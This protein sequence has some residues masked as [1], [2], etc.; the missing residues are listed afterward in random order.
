MSGL[1]E[2]IGILA[3]VPDVYGGYPMSRHHILRRLSRRWKVL[4]VSYPV[5]WLPA[6]RGQVDF[7]RRGLQKVSERLWCYAPRVPADYI[8]EYSG[9]GLG[10][11]LSRQ[12]AACWD[13]LFVRKIKHLLRRMDID[14]VILYIWRPEFEKYMEEFSELFT[15]YHIV[16]E[17]SFNPEADE[18]ISAREMSLLKNADVVFIHSKTLMQ[19]KG[20][21]NPNTHYVPNGVEFSRFRRGISRATG[22][23][24]DI[25]SIPRPRIGYMG[26][27]KRHIDLP[28]LCSIAE[29]R[30]DWSIVLVG[31]VREYHHD[32][33]DDVAALK[34]QPNVHFLGGKPASD[35]PLYVD[36]FDV[37]LMPYQQTQYTKYI[38]PLKLHEYLAC[39]KPVVATPLP[40]L[41]AFSDV[42]Y[43]AENADQW[44]QAIDQALGE[45]D[46]D[47]KVRR[48]RVARENSWDSR[49]EKIAS[50]FDE[51]VEDHYQ[52]IA[53]GMV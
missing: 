53:P 3:F 2:N 6:L 39:G 13:K 26:Y 52:H 5:Y 31:P 51:A 10:Q 21:I 48:V 20:H 4:W 28:L 30:R 1:P 33:K 16:D 8:R 29:A 25:S 47:L 38:Y 35:V 18:P 11:R 23:P 36:A 45:N 7:E 27:I 15:C 12:Y 44:V 49:V 46:P 41:Q 40:N 37:S 9:R 24:S 17:Y 32:I 42:L 22:E 43:F 14:E 34:R 50:I 19:K